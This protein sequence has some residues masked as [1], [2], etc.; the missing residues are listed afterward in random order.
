MITKWLRGSGLV[1]NE[2]KTEICVFH[3]NDVQTVN[4]KVCDSFVKSSK[5]IN[6]LGV[7]FDSK[8]NWSLH[9]ANTIVKAKKALYALKLLKKYF[10]L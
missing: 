9:I 4:V 2:S 8:L 7:I 10:T 5:S 6:V 3:R 1:V